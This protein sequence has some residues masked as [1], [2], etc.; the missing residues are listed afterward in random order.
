MKETDSPKGLSRKNKLM[1]AIIIIGG[2]ITVLNQTVMSPALPTI[3]REFSINASVGQWLTSVFL[4]V[5]G[6]MIPVT[7]WLIG[8]F[9][10]RQLYFVAMTCFIAG[11]AVAA[12]STGFSLLFVGRILQ[13]LG[14][15]IM[16]PFSSVMLMLIFPKERR[17]FAMGIAGIVI[18]L[19]PAFGPTLAGWLVDE[20]GWRYIFLGIAPVSLIVFVFAI[21]FLRNIG[22]RTKDKLDIPSIVLSTLGFGGLLFGF[23]EAG[24]SGWLNPVTLGTIA[25]GAVFV[26]LFVRRELHIADPMLNLRVLGNPTFSVSTVIGAV[27]SAG[28]TVAA[29]ITPIYLQNVLGLSAMHSGLMLMPGALLMAGLSPVSGT[30]FDRFGPRGLAIGGLAIMATGTT[31]LAFLTEHSSVPYILF[32]YSFRMAGMALVNMPVNTW[33]I[34]AL[35][36]RR[37]AHGNAI[38]NTARQVTGSMGTAVLVTVMMITAAGHSQPSGAAATVAGINAA[39]FGATGLT[40]VALV[41]SILFVKNDRDAQAR[42]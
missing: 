25:A 42:Y 11:S 37:I 40:L 26:T 33:G 9:T 14:A 12:F 15:G 30:L 21:I 24:S 3:M 29:V 16:M 18:G 27:V 13:A 22:E 20:F 1:V 10:T 39:F 41:L 5:N 19:G 6:L 38:N 32:A 17:G 31:M 36:N 35:P 7:A 23:S 34:N 8:R 4:L 2:F 28:L